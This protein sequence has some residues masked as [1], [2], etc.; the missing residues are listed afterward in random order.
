LPFEIAQIC[1]HYILTSIK[2]ALDIGSWETEDL[3]HYL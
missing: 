1:T 3:T 2:Y